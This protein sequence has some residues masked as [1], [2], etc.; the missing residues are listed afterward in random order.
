MAAHWSRTLITL[1][2]VV[3]AACAATPVRMPGAVAVTPMR[4]SAR[5]HPSTIGGFVWSADRRLTWA[6]FQGPPDMRSAAVATTATVVDYKMECAGT[7]FTWEIVSWFVP[8]ASWVKPA[9]LMIRQSAQ[10]LVHE[11]VHFDLSEVHSR[12]A[13]ET[14]RRLVDPC[15]LTDAQQDALIQGFHQQ[16]N[17][18]QAQYDRETAHGTDLRRQREWEGRVET[19]LRTLPRF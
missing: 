2:A 6:D 17:A 14:L 15:A 18:L 19:W 13:R 9:H 3:A 11:Q 8:K 10:T 5:D 1:S 12:R 4:S 16:A 7:T